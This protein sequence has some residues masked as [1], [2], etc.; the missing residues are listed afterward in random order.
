MDRYKWVPIADI[1]IHKEDKSV[2]VWPEVRHK[3]TQTSGQYYPSAR[4]IDN[5]VQ[6]ETIKK[7]VKETTTQDRIPQ[8]SLFSSGRGI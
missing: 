3:S 5:R 6:S 8:L 1:I 7:Q 2:T 4:T